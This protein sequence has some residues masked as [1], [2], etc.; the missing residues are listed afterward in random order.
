MAF[1]NRGA[2]HIININGVWTDPAEDARH[3]GWTRDFF[4]AMDPHS[5]GGVYVNFLMHEGEERIRA[6][7]GAGKYERLAELK[8]RYDPEN[9]FR[10][11]QNIR[12]S[13]GEGTSQSL[14]RRGSAHRGR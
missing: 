1:G 14:A 11:N 12:P 10:N 8:N 2:D 6:A 4:A 5:T 9:V 7:Y 3:T 13:V